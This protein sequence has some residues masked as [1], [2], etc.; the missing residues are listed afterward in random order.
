MLAFVLEGL[1]DEEWARRCIYGY[2]TPAERTLSWVA[3][4]TIHEADHHLRDLEASL[5]A[6]GPSRADGSYP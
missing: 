3:Q 4:Q 5:S 6:S 2:P 1:D